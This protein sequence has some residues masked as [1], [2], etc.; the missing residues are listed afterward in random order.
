M[1]ECKGVKD[2]LKIYYNSLINNVI[3]GGGVKTWRIRANRTAQK[4]THQVNDLPGGELT[5]IFEVIKP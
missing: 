4:R 1:K 2:R 5:R 3:H